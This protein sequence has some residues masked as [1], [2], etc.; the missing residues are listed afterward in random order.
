M[1]DRIYFDHN[2]TSPLRPEAKAAMA[3]AL[4]ETGNASSVHA[5]GRAARTHIEA[6]RE[7]VAAL[8]GADPKA[9]TFTSGATESIALALSPDL[10]IDGRKLAC[11]VLM[12]SAVEHPAVRAGGRFPADRIELI[13]VDRDGVVDL[14]A[15]DAMLARHRAAGRRA[16]VSVM[17]ANNETGVFQPLSEIA[18][19]IH[20]AEG[21]FHA[22]AVQIVGRFPF[23]LAASGADLI[24]ISSH[25]IGGPQGAGALIAC[26]DD[27]R[28]PSLLRGGGQEHGR[29]AGTENA[30][31]I[32]GFGAACECASLALAEETGRLAGLRDHLEEGIRKVASDAVILSASAPRVPSTTCFAVP[33]ISAETAVI[34]FDLEGVAVSAGAACSSGKVGPSEALAAMRVAPEIARGALRASLGWSTNDN[35]IARFLKIWKRVHSNLRQRRRERAA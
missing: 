11:D 9:V 5:E 18:P 22:D 15:L 32:T 4:D 21:I 1:A 6:A 16:L 26:D 31:A 25:K 8:V 7:K 30:A 2:A 3:A 27:I 24:S 13:P 35:D 12:V 23:D 14:D 10:E 17:A 20:A 29:R 33:G 34:A 28:V 19:R